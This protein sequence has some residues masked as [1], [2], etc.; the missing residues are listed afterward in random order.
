MRGHP[1]TLEAGETELRRLSPGDIELLLDLA[2]TGME[3]AANRSLLTGVPFD[4][5]SPASLLVTLLSGVR[6]V[7]KPLVEFLCS[8]IPAEARKVMTGPDVG[9]VMEALVTHPDV[10]RFF[11]SVRRVS[12]GEIAAHIRDRLKTPSE[13]SPES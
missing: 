2:C 5:K 10:L 9:T 8:L 6:A 11:G 13:T 3:G 1:V 7:R 4:L 12:Q